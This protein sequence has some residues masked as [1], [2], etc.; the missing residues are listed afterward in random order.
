MR[1]I[2]RNKKM[3]KMKK[4]DFILGQ[5]YKISQKHGSYL[6]TFIFVEPEGYPTNEAVF[7]DNI[8]NHP[9][10]TALNEDIKNYIY[11]PVD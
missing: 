7:F 3:K 1:K 8:E 11:I 5:K 6:G 2:E 4:G 9:G 10:H